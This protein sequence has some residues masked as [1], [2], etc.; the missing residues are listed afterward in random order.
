MA[1]L[2]P[3][4]LLWRSKDPDDSQMDGLGIWIYIRLHV[5]LHVALE[6]IILR[7]SFV[8]S[9]SNMNFFRQ[10][11]HA[12]LRQ[13]R[14]EPDH[15]EPDPRRPGLRCPQAQSS[16]PLPHRLRLCMPSIAPTY[17][18]RE[19]VPHQ[20]FRKKIWT[21]LADTCAGIIGYLL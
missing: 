11:Q 17:E 8:D 12:A 15:L 21:W 3:W 1:G 19:A 13:S 2:L 9:G 14:Q 4:L 10:P 5:Y 20:G 7:W 6:V 18:N 16:G